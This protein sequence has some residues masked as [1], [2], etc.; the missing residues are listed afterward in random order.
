MINKG[1]LNCVV[2]HIKSVEISH[3]Y[4]T[5][6]SIKSKKDNLFAVST[7]R[8]ATFLARAFRTSAIEHWNDLENDLKNIMHDSKFKSTLLKSDVT[9]RSN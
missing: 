3:S 1:K 4:G 2:Q 8:K 6:Y 7:Y 5:L 9:E